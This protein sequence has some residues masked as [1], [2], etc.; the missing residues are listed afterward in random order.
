MMRTLRSLVAAALMAV[1]VYAFTIG[2]LAPL[3]PRAIGAPDLEVVHR[4]TLPAA[5]HIEVT[6]ANGPIRIRTHADPGIVI[7][8][9]MRAYLQRNSEPAEARR[10]LEHSVTV[11]SATDSARITVAAPDSPPFLAVETALAVTVPQGASVELENRNGNV[12]AGAGC[13]PLTVRGGNADIEIQDPDSDVF[14]ETTNGRIR[15][16]N[17][18]GQTVLH[19]VNGNVYAHVSGGTLDAETVNGTVVARLLSPAVSACRAST[20]NGGVVLNVPQ[21]YSAQI[22]AET[23]RGRI[24]CDLPEVRQTTTG[25]NRLDATVGSGEAR[26]ELATLNGNILIQYGSNP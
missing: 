10:T 23:A 13:G 24:R 6:G 14:V 9:T 26:A 8:A 11:E 18:S 4:Q 7:E 15:V 1:A 19:T 25:T 21:G 2:V 17:A 20:G 5:G 16:V 12:W 22:A 3:L